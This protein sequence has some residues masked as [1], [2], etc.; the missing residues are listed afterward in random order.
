[1]TSF[2]IHTMD[3][4]P[5]E[6]RETLREVKETL[7]MIP[8][9]AAGMAESP[10][11]VRAF[12]AVRKAFSHGTLSPIEI[13]VLSLTNAFENGCEWC[14]A[15]HSGVALKEG[16]SKEALD[17]LRAG[18]RPED[19]RLGALSDLSRA[20]VRNRGK[21]SEAELEA[22]CAAGFSKAQA[23]EVVLG[24]GFSV[25]ANFSGHLVHAPLGAAF[26]PYAWTM[27]G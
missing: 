25:M 11:L 7:G 21:V 10:A 20:M 23:L 5:E 27:P 1:M 9:L 13:Q 17:A 16:L 3:T 18:R 14:M 24:A 22:F 15:F 19:S 26:E 8:N 4:A 2:P 6:S 12:F